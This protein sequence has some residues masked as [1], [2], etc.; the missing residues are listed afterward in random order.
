MIENDKKLSHII[1][2]VNKKVPEEAIRSFCTNIL[3]EDNKIWFTYLSYDN[4]NTSSPG[5]ELSDVIIEGTKKDGLFVIT[6]SEE[7][8]AYAC[9][10]GIACAGLGRSLQNGEDSLKLLYC[11][12]DI[13][14]MSLS[15]INRMW[16]RY[17]GIPWTIACTERLVIREQTPGDLDGLYEIYSDKEIVRYTED[18]FEDREEEA[19]YMRSY[20]ENQYRFYEYGIW[21]ITLKDTGK[22]IGRAGI[23]LREGFDIPEVGYVIGKKYQ[24]KGYAKEAMKAIIEYAAEELEMSDLIAFTKEKN[25]ASVKLLESLGFS[26]RGHVL[27]KGGYHSMYLLTK[28][29]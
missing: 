24:N 22:L 1:I 19:E 29:Q 11:I 13:E 3:S 15:R 23:S 28:R 25:T 20:I 26:R 4:Q 12:E 8:A 2:N 18:L 6:D 21:A 27:I 14:Y 16:E 17:H 9:D 10:N 5:R 7:T